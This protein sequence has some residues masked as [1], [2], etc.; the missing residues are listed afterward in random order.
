MV[1]YICQC[2]S[3]N[4]FPLSFPSVST[5]L[6]STSASLNISAAI[7]AYT[8]V[9]TKILILKVIGKNYLTYSWGTTKGLVHTQCKLRVLKSYKSTISW[10]RS[11][12]RGQWF[13]V[14]W[15]KKF[16]NMSWV[17]HPY[18][19]IPIDQKNGKKKK[20]TWVAGQEIITTK[21]WRKGPQY[22]PI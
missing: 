19:S 6:F 7:A 4:L 22:D 14:L 2:Y 9:A 16:M 21:N 13:E 1:V 11:L 12:A 10:G 8:F 5:C 17:A 18:K 15:K 20:K 3:P